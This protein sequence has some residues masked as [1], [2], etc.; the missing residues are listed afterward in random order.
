MADRLLWLWKISLSQDT[1]LYPERNPTDS[2]SVNFQL[3]IS[4]LDHILTLHTHVRMTIGL[5]NHMVT[6]HSLQQTT[7][8]FGSSK[9]TP[10]I[11]GQGIPGYKVQ[12][13]SLQSPV[14][15]RQPLLLHNYFRDSS[16]SWVCSLPCESLIL[17]SKWSCCVVW[18]GK[19]LRVANF[20]R[21]TW[22]KS[23]DIA[24]DLTHTL[25]SLCLGLWRIFELDPLS[26]VRDVPFSYHEDF[27]PNGSSQFFGASEASEV[28]HKRVTK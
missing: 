19:F 11:A 5:A 16:S 9:F 8:K 12:Q 7:E 27:T 14:K 21:T 15:S 10:W 4:S 23:L 3:H 24:V 20:W 2:T 28:R 6:H 25:V 18:F 22:S 26:E 1:V 17:P 13:T